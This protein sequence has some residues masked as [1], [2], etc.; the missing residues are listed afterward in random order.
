[1]LMNVKGNIDKIIGKN[2]WGKVER[3]GFSESK[4]KKKRTRKPV[5]N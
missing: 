3:K 2:I 5:S 1:M 4:E